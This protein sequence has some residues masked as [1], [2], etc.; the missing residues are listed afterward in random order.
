MVRPTDCQPVG[1]RGVEPR[2]AVGVWRMVLREGGNVEAGVWQQV[3]SEG[4]EESGE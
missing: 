1:E 2:A 3:E 4:V